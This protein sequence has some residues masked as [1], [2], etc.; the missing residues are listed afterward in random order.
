M[1]RTRSRA[2]PSRRAA[3]WDLAYSN[4]DAFNNGHSQPYLTPRQQNETPVDT[5]PAAKA[6][7]AAAATAAAAAFDSSVHT[8]A[9]ARARRRRAAKSSTQLPAGSHQRLLQRTARAATRGGGPARGDSFI[10]EDELT[11]IDFESLSAAFSGGVSGAAA[12]SSMIQ[13]STTRS[14]PRELAEHGAV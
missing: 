9:R 1:T 2:A 11:Q 14:T 6:A 4:S 7:A 12:S 10:T 3:H 5:T 8:L 13:E